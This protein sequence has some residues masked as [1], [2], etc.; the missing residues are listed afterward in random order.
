[1]LLNPARL[2]VLDLS[3]NPLGE[4]WIAASP[5]WP[6]NFV[7]QR[8]TLQY[9]NEQPVAAEGRLDFFPRRCSR[10]TAARADMPATHRGVRV[11]RRQPARGARHERA[12]A[13][14][15]PAPLLH[16]RLAQRDRRG[17]AANTTLT[18]I[19]LGTTACAAAAQSGM[20][21]ASLAQLL[22]GDAGDASSPS[23]RSAS[24][25]REPPPQARRARAQLPRR[26][27]GAVLHSRSW[28][29][30]SPSSTCARTARSAPSTHVVGAA[31]RGVRWLALPAA[32]PP[33]SAT[34]TL[35][36]C[37]SCRGRRRCSRRAAPTSRARR[38]SARRRGARRG[39][40]RCAST[41]GRTARSSC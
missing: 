12:A 36:S 7:L 10:A 1:M 4:T 19:D 22:A 29:A 16:R 38:S 35:P 17:L 5:T 20:P 21:P 28:A 34:P 37:R 18:S 33:A 39:C 2:E 9:V 23:A 6:R 13:P 24:A 14:P 32:L 11:Q 3:L 41:C 25:P 40:R 15:Q 26:P 8:L 30:R 31:P 27:G